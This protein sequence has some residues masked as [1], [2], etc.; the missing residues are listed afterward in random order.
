MKEIEVG[1][2][3]KKPKVLLSKNRYIHKPIVNCAFASTFFF[4]KHTEGVWKPCPEQIFRHHFSSSICSLHI[5]LSHFGHS[6]GVS[7]LFIITVCVTVICDQWSW[8]YSCHGLGQGVGAARELNNVVFVL[9]ASL[10]AVPPSLSSG[11]PA[12]WHTV[13]K[14]G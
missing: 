4:F 2:L 3:V 14:L 1:K 6:H 11:L 13:L 10:T 12:P 5:S 9:P 8:C 7:N